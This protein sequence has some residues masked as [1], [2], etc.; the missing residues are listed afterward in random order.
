MPKIKGRLFITGDTHQNIDIHK[1]NSKKFS[2]GNELS[3]QDI[4]VITGDA[5]FVW[6]CGLEANGEEKFWRNWIDKKPWTT[7]CTLGNHECYNFIETFPIVEFCGG[8]A[9][10]ISD[11]IYYEIR[12]EIYNLNG[13]ICLSLGGAESIDKKFRKEGISWWPQEQITEDDIRRARKNLKRYSYKVD[14]I[15]THTGGINVSSFLG[16]TPTISDVRLDEILHEIEYSHHYC[17][18]YH[19]DMNVDEKTRILYNDI[20]EI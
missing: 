18:H 6:S 1:L 5:G 19:V 14:Y 8:K 20:L 13:K 11:S 4:L 2:I 10:K 9:R 12:G 15:F 3:K 7:F 16:F 17:G